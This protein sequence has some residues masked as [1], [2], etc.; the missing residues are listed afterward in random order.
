[1]V[2]PAVGLSPGNV[3]YEGVLGLSNGETG[4]FDF[5]DTPILAA[6]QSIT[7]QFKYETDITVAGSSIIISIEGENVVT[8]Q[9]VGLLVSLAINPA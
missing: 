5:T 8:G 2:D 7:V 6:G 1:V 3:T 9:R 4:E